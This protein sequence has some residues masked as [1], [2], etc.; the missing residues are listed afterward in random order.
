MPLMGTD[1]PMRTLFCFGLLPAFFDIDGPRRKLVFEALLDAYK[2][3]T[4]RFGITVLGTLDDDRSVVG[5]ALTYPWT[6]YILADVPSH[7]AVTEFCN[8]LREVQVGEDLLW[9]YL[10][11]E[12][13]TGRELFFGRN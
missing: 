10:K 13:R 2:D 7:Q 6:C 5:P 11:I 1:T 3:L 8:I 12:A 4:G 9:R